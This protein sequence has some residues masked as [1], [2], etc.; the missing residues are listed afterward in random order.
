[1]AA[2]VG[3][4]YRPSVAILGGLPAI[5]PDVVISAIYIVLFLGMAAANMTILQVNKRRRHR[6]PISGMLYGL[7]MARVTT[8]ILRIA[9]ATA[10]RNARLGLAATIFVNC[11]IVLLYVANLVFAQRVLR[12]R[13]PPLGWHPALRVVVWVAYAC[14]VA[15]LVMAITSAVWNAYTV[16]DD[17]RAKLL[18]RAL[19]RGAST[20]L[21][22]VAT[23]PFLLLALA[24]LLPRCY[25]EEAFG[26]GSMLAKML[27][28][29]LSALLCVAIACFKTGAAWA[30][31]R[32]ISAPAW[33]HGLAPFYLF[34]FTLELV[35]VTL[36][37]ASR[38]DQRF[39]V[40]DG[41]RKPGDYSRGHSRLSDASS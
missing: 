32:H 21:L 3:P 17:V 38:V 31:A 2:A 22:V 20:M 18:C 10:P 23:L 11:G 5:V 16:P 41:S 1:M 24:T 19:L 28:L 35:D 29:A 25:D 15:S 9:W 26:R 37:T 14:I 40:P 6:F 8:L 4:P 39:H 27:V 33:Y 34:I 30:P 36:L 12:A 13:Q 7:C